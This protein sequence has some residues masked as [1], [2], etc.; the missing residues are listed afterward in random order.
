MVCRNI[1]NQRE[2]LLWKQNF[3]TKNFGIFDEKFNVL[4]GNG[5]QA[6]DLFVETL[7]EILCRDIETKSAARDRGGEEITVPHRNPS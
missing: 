7:Q 2:L 5:P 6:M 1:Q 3:L 4:T